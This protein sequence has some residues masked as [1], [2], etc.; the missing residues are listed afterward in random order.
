MNSLRIYKEDTTPLLDFNIETMEFF[1]EGE[2]RP[3][4][5]LTYFEPILKWLDSYV[6]WL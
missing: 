5:V 3:E 2:C 1:M 4:N 6:D